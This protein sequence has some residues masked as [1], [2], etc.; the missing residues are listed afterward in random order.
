MRTILQR[1]IIHVGILLLLMSGIYT[2]YIYGSFEFDF[3]K[4]AIFVALASAINLSAEVFLLFLLRKGDPK[5]KLMKV[6]FTHGFKFL[7]YLVMALIGSKFFENLRFFI[8]FLLFLYFF[9][10]AIEF[11]FLRKH[12]RM[13]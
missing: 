11:F 2:L 13:P 12:S 8:L 6:F 7:C 9:Y 10:G 5:A 4:T 3:F 1:T